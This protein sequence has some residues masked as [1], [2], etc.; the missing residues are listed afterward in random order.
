M[1]PLSSP[2]PSSLLSLT[3]DLDAIAAN[4]RILCATA[5]GAHSAA[6]VKA[7]AYGL[8][9][10]HVA[11]KLAQAGCDVF[12]V[13]TIEEGI[14]LRALLASARLYVLSGPPPGAEGECVA[15]GI[16]PVINS[17]EQLAA[18]RE[19]AARL[20]VELE[21]ALHVDTGM[22]RLG[23]S[24]SDVLAIASDPALLTGI[25]PILGMTHLACADTP[26]HPMNKEQLAVFTNAMARLPPMPQ[27]VAASSGVFLN[28]LFHR[29]LARHG[30]ALYGVNPNGKTAN[31]MRQT[32][33]LRAKI[34]QI[35]DVDTPQRVGYGATHSVDRPGRIATVG[36]GYADG[37]LRSL[38]NKGFGTIGGLKV[39]V[40]GRISMDLTTFDISAVPTD[41]AR[42]G[43]WLEVIGSDHTIDD[44][45]AE[46][47]TIAYEIL[48]NLPHRAHRMYIGDTR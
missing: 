31:P 16:T 15:H 34:L 45:A 18:W 21:A 7:N 14:G 4:W 25:K 2:P 47:G 46:A 28:P 20:G 32:V 39:P 27:S 23:F 33:T 41:R 38:G 6:V 30:A 26:D 13:A 8:G 44:V 17:L 10:D 35:R 5:A 40:V 11:P 22:T 24:L 3:I 48:T 19:H 43:D 1:P 12:F 37:Y 36:I 29:D 9:V 42:P